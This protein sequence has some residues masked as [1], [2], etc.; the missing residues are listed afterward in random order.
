[1]KII[2]SSFGTYYSLHPAKIFQKN[3]NLVKYI[4][5]VPKKYIENHQ[6]FPNKKFLSLK[7]PFLIGYV[8]IKFR[9]LLGDNLYSKILRYSHNSFS[10][11]LAKNIKLPFDFFIGSSSYCSEALFKAKKLNPKCITIVDHASLNEEFEL[12]QKIIEE[13]KFGFKL[14]GNSL[15]KWLINKEN[16]EH[17]YTDYI[18][19][20]SYLAKKTF[21]DRGFSESKLIVN[22]FYA[23]TTKFQKTIK[24]DKKFRVL[25]C[26]S[27]EPRKGIH[28]LL[29]AF[30]RLQIENAELWVIGS[31]DYLKKDKLFKKFI[32]K[33]KNE[34]IIY[35]D[36]I[37]SNNLADYFSQ[38]S[39]LVLPS[40]S[41][42]FGLVVIQ[43]MSC[44]LPVIV[45][46]NTGAK[47]LIKEGHNGFIVETRNII[48]LSEKINYFYKNPKKIN[49]M[50]NNAFETVQNNYTKE[51]YGNRWK[52]ILNQLA[53]K[54]K[55]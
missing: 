16:K 23:N 33:S 41:D 36:T 13:K 30:N 3:G 49:E 40:I 17:Q 8:C 27:I 26:G 39:V 24:R 45:S 44:N 47:D 12:E 14:T 50:G 7:V 34:K 10:K 18:V 38:C 37:N 11:A 25:F 28:Y 31:Q 15:H 55:I 54:Q 6:E 53:N 43:A 48:S 52:K 29:E 22:H 21:I 19:L 35:F 20:P 2:I 1:M 5:G 42:G 32:D 46:E 51:A 9:L 4:T